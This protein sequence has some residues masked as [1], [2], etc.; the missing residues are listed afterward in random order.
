MKGFTERDLA[1][2]RA[3]HATDS[4]IA[5]ALAHEAPAAPRKQG[6]KGQGWGKDTER[7]LEESLRLLG[8]PIEPQYPWGKELTPPRKFV[9]DVRI[10]GTRIL[11]ESVGR[12]HIA[13]GDRLDVDTERSRLAAQGGWIIWPYSKAE[14][15]SGFAALDVAEQ[16]KRLEEK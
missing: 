11:V 9:A 8:V 6:R 16:L 1:E 5:D 14:I 7:R 3:R 12:A 2:Y 15:E 13:G 4:R 10:S